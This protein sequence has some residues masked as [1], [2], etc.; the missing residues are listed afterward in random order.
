MYF[1]LSFRTRGLFNT[2][3][4]IATN[5]DFTATTPI[6][7]RDAHQW[8]TRIA[9]IFHTLEN[10]FRQSWDINLDHEAVM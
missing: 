5:A 10:R 1:L 6:A 7:D 9:A 3:I 2:L 4:T 8:R